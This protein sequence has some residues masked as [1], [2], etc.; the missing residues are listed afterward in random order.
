[1]GAPWIC[2]HPRELKTQAHIVQG[3]DTKPGLDNPDL[4]WM[5]SVNKGSKWPWLGCNSR[6]GFLGQK[7]KVGVNGDK[8]RGDGEQYRGKRSP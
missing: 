2:C 5:E 1:M 8:E 7:W 6:A 4:G 3:G